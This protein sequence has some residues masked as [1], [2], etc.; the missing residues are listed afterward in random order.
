MRVLL[1]GALL[2][3]ACW[4]GA[5]APPVEPVAPAQR[6]NVEPTRLRVTLER[7]VCFG[8]CPAYVVAIDGAGRVEWTGNAHVAAMGKRLGQLTRRELDELSR[9]I[10]RARFFERNEFGDIPEK[11]DCVTTGNTTQCSF[12]TS[13][14]ICSD[15]SHSIIT[16]SRNG[17]THKIDNDHCNES[18]ELDDLEELI[19]RITQ[20]EAW[21][22]P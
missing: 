6:P 20:T 22:S 21:I 2:L 5:E 12:G 13:V 7:T 19:E 16:V 3:G 11:F 14:T 10:D 9:Q 18:P 4:R 15:T 8:T 1:A 17:R